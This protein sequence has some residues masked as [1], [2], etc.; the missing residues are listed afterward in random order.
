VTLSHNLITGGALGSQQFTNFVIPW[1]T[2]ALIVVA[3]VLSAAVLTWIPAR[4]AASVPI[5]EALR[6][7]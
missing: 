6:Y 5:A 7:D 2:I 4:K 1:S 3:T